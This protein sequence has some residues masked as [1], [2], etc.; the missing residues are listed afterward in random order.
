MTFALGWL[1]GKTGIGRPSVDP[2]SLSVLERQ[3]TERM[4]GSVLVGQFTI[5]NREGQ[6]LYAERYELSSVEKVGTDQWRFN[7]HMKYG[8]VDITVPV[9]VT[10]LWA[11]DTPM[12][13]ITDLTIPTVGTWAGHGFSGHMFGQIQKME[14]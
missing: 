12:I 10:M 6:E 3:F 2:A 7:A 5:T 1:I 9:T 8:S 4:T 14:D 11:G 13:S